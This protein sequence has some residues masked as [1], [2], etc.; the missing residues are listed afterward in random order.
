MPTNNLCPFC[1]QGLPA[2]DPDAN[3][4]VGDVVEVAATLYN[5]SPTLKEGRRGVVVGFIKSD[6]PVVV[7]IPLPFVDAYGTTWR[8]K[9]GEDSLHVFFSKEEL[10]KVSE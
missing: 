10:R 2:T 3:L 8:R 1:G 6:R 9:G 5:E 4:S 7:S